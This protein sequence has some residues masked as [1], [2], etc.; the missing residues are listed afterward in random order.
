M[1]KIVFFLLHEGKKAVGPKRLTAFLY[2][3]II[4]EKIISVMQYFSCKT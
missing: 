1:V 2:A 3:K 4:C